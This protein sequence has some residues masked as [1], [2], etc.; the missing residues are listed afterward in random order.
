MSKKSQKFPLTKGQL[1]KIVDTLVHPHFKDSPF[2][3][4]LDTMLHA[5]IEQN[6]E[7]SFKKFVKYNLD[8]FVKNCVKYVSKQNKRRYATNGCKKGYRQ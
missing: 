8:K 7:V 4:V 3:I 6:P 1:N 2:F 5:L